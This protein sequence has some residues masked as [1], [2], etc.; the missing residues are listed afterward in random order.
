MDKLVTSNVTA[1]CSVRPTRVNIVTSWVTEP[2]R[3]GLPS[4]TYSGTGWAFLA[5]GMLFLRQKLSSMNVPVAPE[6]TRPNVEISG[7]DRLGKPSGFIGGQSLTGSTRG[8][9]ERLGAKDMEA[10]EIVAQRSVVGLR[11]ER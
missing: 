4:M 10:A 2:E 9:D 11:E 5:S 1:C 7:S 3:M 6:S 8:S